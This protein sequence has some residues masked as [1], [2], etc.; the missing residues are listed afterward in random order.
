MSVSNVLKK[1]AS[2]FCLKYAC[3]F[4]FETFESNVEDFTF[5]RPNNGWIDV[6][7]TTFKNMY[8]QALEFSSKVGNVTLDGETMLDD[9]EYTLIRPYVNEGEKEIKHN[10]YVGMDRVSRIAYLQLLTSQSPSNSVDLY[11]KKYKSGELSMKQIRSRL[12]SVSGQER[13]IELVEFSQALER[14]NQSRSMIWRAFHPFK[15]NAEKRVSA[16]MKQ[17]FADR[18]RGDSECYS[19]ALAEAYKIFDGHRMVIASLEER[20]LHAQ[21]E[22]NRMQKMSDAMRES[23]RQESFEG[24]KSRRVTPY[25]G[26]EGGFLL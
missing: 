7:K 12:D 8:M 17:A 5:L 23:M 3:N 24:V 13:Y 9:F 4:D 19:E 2:D 22:R 1:S 21:E 14:V 20:M 6:Y 25:K 10:P 15:N 11:A 16:Q 26:T 18:K